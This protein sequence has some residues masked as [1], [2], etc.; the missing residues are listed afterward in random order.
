MTLDEIPQYGTFTAV[1]EPVRRDDL[2]PGVE[3]SIGQRFTWQKAWLMGDDD[4]NPGEWACTV[5]ANDGRTKDLLAG[6]VW[7]P[8]CDLADLAAA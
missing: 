3:A 6:Y 5:H 7:A 1:F 2:K 8:G 4:P